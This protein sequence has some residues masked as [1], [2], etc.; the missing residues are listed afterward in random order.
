MRPAG[1]PI[2]IESVFRGIGLTLRRRHRI[3]SARG[4]TWRTVIF[5]FLYRAGKRS[6]GHVPSSFPALRS[7]RRKFHST[8]AL[9]VNGER[10]EEDHEIIIRRMMTDCRELYGENHRENF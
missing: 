9:I 2:L 10:E 7:E 8:S 6:R 1:N 5:N 4:S 3:Y